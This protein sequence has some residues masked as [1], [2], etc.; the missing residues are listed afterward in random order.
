M[1][2]VGVGRGFRS[3]SKINR[4][5]RESLSENTDPH[6]LGWLLFCSGPLLC[7]AVRAAGGDGTEL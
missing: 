2:Q 5:Q 3:I 4:D 6:P 7:G 1:A